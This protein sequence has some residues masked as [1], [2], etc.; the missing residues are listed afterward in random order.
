MNCPKDRYRVFV[1]A[2][3]CTDRTAYIARAH[4]CDVHERTNRDLVGKGHALDWLVEQVQAQYAP[5]VFVFMDADAVAPANLLEAFDRKFS[6]G[7]RALQAHYG[8]SDPFRSWSTTMRAGAMLLFNFVRPLGRQR[9]GL[10]SGLKGTGMA[11]VADLATSNRWGASLA[12]DT[13]Y[14]ARLVMRGERVEFVPDVAVT[15]EIPTLLSDATEQNKRWEA[16]RVAAARTLGW[17]LLRLAVA[18]RRLAPADAAAD[19]IVPPL[20]IL[21]TLSGGC[22]LVGLVVPGPTFVLGLIACAALAWHVLAGLVAAKAPRAYY[23]AL[24][25]TPQFVLWKLVVYVAALVNGPK[26]WIRT[27]RDKH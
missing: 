21:A 11:L 9:L 23:V 7:A 2:D 18:K 26:S 19:L 10:S 15:A 5:D 20:S 13:E 1:V 4:G 3:N 12:E 16:G 6:G 22:L 27:D 14:H 17:P 25:R 8:I 24:L